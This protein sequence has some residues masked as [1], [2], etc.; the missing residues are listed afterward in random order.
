M[1]IGGDLILACVIFWVFLHR[2]TQEGGSVTVSHCVCSNPDLY[3]CF[4]ASSSFFCLQSGALVCW[5]SII[6]PFFSLFPRPS[7]RLQMEILRRFGFLTSDQRLPGMRVAAS[8]DYGDKSFLLSGSEQV[9]NA[10]LI[11]CQGSVVLFL[12]FILWASVAFYVLLRPSYGC[13]EF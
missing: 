5:F 8:S 7:G 13:N 1:F 3:G 6:S 2:P 12:G 10:R 9:K 11:G 4:S